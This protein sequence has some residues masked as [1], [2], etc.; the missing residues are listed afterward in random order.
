MVF[1]LSVPPELRTLSGSLVERTFTSMSV[2]Q[3]HFTTAE[4]VADLHRDDDL[5]AGQ[6]HGLHNSSQLLL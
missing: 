2:D 5:G 6:W 3:L 1:L 4:D